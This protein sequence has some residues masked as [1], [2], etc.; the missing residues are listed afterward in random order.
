MATARDGVRAMRDA[1]GSYLI[2]RY[3]NE[4]PGVLFRE[5]DD[6][7]PVGVNRQGRDPVEVEP[8]DNRAPFL[9]PDEIADVLRSYGKPVDI[10]IMYPDR[11]ES[12][13]FTGVYDRPLVLRIYDALEADVPVIIDGDNLRRIE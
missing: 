7:D 5:P 8:V 11:T 2:E 12:Y 1:F 13:R 10:S 4:H 9:F 3:M 6:A